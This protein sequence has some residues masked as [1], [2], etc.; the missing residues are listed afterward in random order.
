[1]KHPEDKY[2]KKVDYVVAILELVNLNQ[3]LELLLL[4]LHTA[5]IY[6]R[7]NGEQLASVQKEMFLW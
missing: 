1:M 4:L 5:V 3:L 6:P 7:Q 2:F